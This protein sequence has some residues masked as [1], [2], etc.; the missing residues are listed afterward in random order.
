MWPGAA[1]MHGYV[2]TFHPVAQLRMELITGRIVSHLNFLTYPASPRPMPTKW[3][4]SD[5][6]LLAD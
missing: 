5:C 2:H 6:R 3:P 1:A 4:G